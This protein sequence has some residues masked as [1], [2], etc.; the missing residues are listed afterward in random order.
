[1]ARVWIYLF[2]FR[3]D[4]QDH[5]PAIV[6]DAMMQTTAARLRSTKSRVKL[7]AIPCDQRTEQSKA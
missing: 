6:V 3:H 1:M 2:V 5:H 7:N 4:H